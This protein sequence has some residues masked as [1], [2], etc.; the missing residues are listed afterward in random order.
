MC[1][2]GPEQGKAGLRGVASGVEKGE[3]DTGAALGR[4]QRG[5]GVW[6]DD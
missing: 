2:L 5:A 6:T 1:W 4:L 3:G